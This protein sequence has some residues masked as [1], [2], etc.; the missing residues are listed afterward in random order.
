MKT[1]ILTALFVLPLLF[2]VSCEKSELK[3]LSTGLVSVRMM[4]DTSATTYEEVNIDVH[5]IQVHIAGS[6][7]GDWYKLKTTSGVY[8][9]LTLS[10]GTSALLVN[11]K[12]PTGAITGVRLN[13]GSNNSIRKNGV[14]YP[15]VI[16]PQDIAALEAEIYGMI[17]S[18]SFNMNLVFDG[19]GS[20]VQDGQESYHMKPVMRVYRDTLQ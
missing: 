13:L 16:L 3:N 17:G 18:K 12:V 10:N 2:I 5:S 14:L 6:T 1:K 15:V 4:N 20:I 19:P 9:V 11:E 7:G 8:N